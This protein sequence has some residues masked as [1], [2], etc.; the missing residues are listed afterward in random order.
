M[1]LIFYKN[2]SHIVLA[3]AHDISFHHKKEDLKPLD[4]VT[5]TETSP[6]EVQN[7]KTSKSLIK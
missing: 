4:S 2:F 1:K 7:S 5:P 3:E 6:I